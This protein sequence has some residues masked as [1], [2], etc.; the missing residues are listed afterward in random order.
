[1]LWRRDLAFAKRAVGAFKETCSS[2]KNDRVERKKSIAFAQ[3]RGIDAN[4]ISDYRAGVAAPSTS[5]RPWLT[6]SSTD[7]T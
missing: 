4:F 5:S 1:M 2:V 7:K 3:T 6:V